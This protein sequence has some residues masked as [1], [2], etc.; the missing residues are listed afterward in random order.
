MVRLQYR[1][2]VSYYVRQILKKT[3]DFIS[4]KLVLTLL[5]I[6]IPMKNSSKSPPTTVKAEWNSDFRFGGKSA[7]ASKS[8]LFSFVLDTFQA[9]SVIF[10]TVQTHEEEY[11]TSG[12]V[13]E[14]NL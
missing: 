13:G 4:L 10:L 6:L 2:H 14:Q 3:A 5:T 7:A 8:L 12:C 11:Q 9:I 1:F